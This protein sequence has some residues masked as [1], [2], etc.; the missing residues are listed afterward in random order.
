MRNYLGDFNLFAF[1]A[2]VKQASLGVESA[3]D[4]TFQVDKGNV[5]NLTPRRETNEAA[6]LGHHESDKAY[7][8]GSLGEM[9]VDFNW[10]EAQ[11]FA[12]LYSFAYGNVTP[13]AWGTGYKHLILP[14]DEMIVPCGTGVFRYGKPLAKRR[15]ADVFVESVTS[16]FAKDSWA[17]VQG[18]L[19]AS[20]KH[21]DNVTSE[22]ITG[23]YNATTLN[24]AA[25]GV[26]GLDAPS[27]LDSIHLVRVQ[28]PATGEWKDVACTA[29]SDATPAVLTITA[30]G[31][32]A[33]STV[34]EVIYVP[35]EAAWATF[36][37]R[38]DESPLRV[39]DL[40]FKI[41]GKYNPAT[42]VIDGGHVMAEE[43]DSVIHTVTNELPIEFR[44]GGTG[45]YANYALLKG[46]TQTIKLS[47]QMRDYLMQFWIDKNEYLG[48]QMTA[49]GAEFETGKNYYVDMIFPRCSVLTAPLSVADKVVAEAGDLRIH[50]DATA[51]LSS[52]I[53][54]ANQVA[55]YAQA[56]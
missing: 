56:T 10:A 6:L 22:L 4:T 34:Y 35:I 45:S 16:T 39:T 19:K 37:A 30:P 43:I 21:D 53:E 23:A 9:A 49:T 41:G 7:D 32:V 20:G 15:F 12:W 26:Q 8:L 25:N 27:R 52:R 2:N 38:V 48:I 5:F 33:T 11:H 18:A 28:V 40:V 54:V 55:K 47:R 44:V 29:A 51:G 14:T 42:H 50:Y 31:G 17:K 24:L 1:S 13:S 3:I 36:P 46:R